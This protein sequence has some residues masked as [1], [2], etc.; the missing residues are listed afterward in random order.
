MLKG[1][2]FIQFGFPLLEVKLSHP[3]VC[4]FW[5]VLANSSQKVLMSPLL[6]TKHENYNN[7]VIDFFKCKIQEFQIS[8]H[9]SCLEGFNT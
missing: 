5:K 4:Y 2:T 3:T 6:E 9:G 1:E 8:G 7:K